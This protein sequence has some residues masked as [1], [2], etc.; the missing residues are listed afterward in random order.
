MS[1]SGSFPAAAHSVGSEVGSGG[2]QEAGR[3]A[4]GRAARSQAARKVDGKN[5]CQICAHKLILFF[6][7]L[8]FCCVV[9]AGL[10]TLLIEIVR[11]FIF[12]FRSLMAF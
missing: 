9:V 6:R 11:V 8:Y 1:L 12:S 10:E 5:R 7:L 2:A 4:A 3:G